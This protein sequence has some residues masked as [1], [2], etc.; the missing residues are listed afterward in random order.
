MPPPA[1]G[2]GEGLGTGLGDG[3]GEGEGEGDGLGLGLGEGGGGELG[4]GFD[5]A[6]HLKGYKRRFREHS[7]VETS[8]SQQHM[9]AP[10]SPAGAY[11]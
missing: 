7:W 4:A 11:Q 5:A 6:P 10:H 1:G 9:P 3:E 8:S 2:G